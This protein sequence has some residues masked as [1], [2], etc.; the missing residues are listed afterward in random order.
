[1]WQPTQKINYPFMVS[2]SLY[3]TSLSYW[4]TLLRLFGR[5][6]YV[7]TR[8]HNH[9]PHICTAAQRMAGCTK[10]VQYTYTII[11]CSST[12]SATAAYLGT[13]GT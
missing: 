3:I 7:D 9:I 10:P 6:L 4:P 2:P 5:C 13:T 8:S 12:N 11:G 1:M